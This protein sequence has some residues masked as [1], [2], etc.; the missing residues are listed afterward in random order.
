MQIVVI[1]AM[2]IAGLAILFAVQNNNPVTITFLT[3]KVQSPLALVLLIAL[4]TGALISL[5]ASLP[6]TTRDKLNLRS[7]RKRVS[8]LE[9]SLSDH[10]TRLDEAQKKLQ[11]QETEKTET[12]IERE[13]GKEAGN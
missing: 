13:T 11:S 5:L 12:K 8:E 6:T 3:W 2:F 1:F 9:A 4:A 10:K 7:H